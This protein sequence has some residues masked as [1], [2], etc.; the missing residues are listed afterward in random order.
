M[1]ISAQPM[2]AGYSD[3]TIE[4]L[5]NMLDLAKKDDSWICSIDEIAEHWNRLLDLKIEINEK[6]NEL[7]IKF[8]TE[9]TIDELS[10]KLAKK[11]REIIFKGKYIIKQIDDDI[12]LILEEVNNLEQV[13]VRY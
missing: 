7:D 3:Q 12:F 9:K 8:E 6:G 13:I 5:Q 2:F 11:P 4:P 1:I 10:L